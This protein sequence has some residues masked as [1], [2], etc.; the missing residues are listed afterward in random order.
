LTDLDEYYGLRPKIHRVP[1]FPRHKLLSVGAQKALTRQA[2][3][4]WSRSDR[5]SKEGS[6]AA[7]DIDQ[8]L[9]ESL[10]QRGSTPG[11]WTHVEL[12]DGS[13]SRHLRLPSRHHG[14]R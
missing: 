1:N 5:E 13:K 3:F 2:T 4:R 14:R 9:Q 11:K 8:Y 10:F 12:H 6:A 7:E